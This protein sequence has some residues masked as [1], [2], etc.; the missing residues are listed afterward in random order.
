VSNQII[1]H[2]I[3]DVLVYASSGHNTRGFEAVVVNGRD[4]LNTLT[5]LSCDFFQTIVDGGQARS[6][7]L[8]VFDRIIKAWRGSKIDRV[9]RGA[10]QAVVVHCPASFVPAEPAVKVMLTYF[11]LMANTMGIGTTWAGYFMV[12]GGYAP[13]KEYLG[14]PKENNIYGAMMFGWPAFSYPLIPKRPG[15]QIRYAP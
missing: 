7:D 5:G 14:I 9:F 3:N 2:I 4:K 13:I 11:E 10:N 8:K 6:F 15:I 1:E 12:A